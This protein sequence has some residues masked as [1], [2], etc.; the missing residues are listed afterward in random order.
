M[1][2][3][4]VFFLIAAIAGHGGYV[5]HRVATGAFILTLVGF[6]ILTVGGWL[7]GAIVY[8]HGMRVLNLVEEPAQRAVAPVPHE[9][10]VEAES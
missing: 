4:T 3:A 2:T 7:G 9:E 8:V 1:V 6:A 10:K 5:D